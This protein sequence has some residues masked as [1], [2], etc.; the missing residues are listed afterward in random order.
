MTC[1]KNLFF[2]QGLF[3]NVVFLPLTTPGRGMNFF[4]KAKIEETQN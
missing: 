3:S 2:R 4:K 1:K